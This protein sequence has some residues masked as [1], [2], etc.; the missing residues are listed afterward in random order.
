MKRYFRITLTLFIFSW[1][2]ALTFL[3]L[4]IIMG[5]TAYSEIFSLIYPLQYVGLIIAAFLSEGSNVRA[6]K[7][8]N[9][10]CVLTGMFLGLT[11]G[12][13]VF[14]I[15]IA[16][17]DKFIMFMNM[18]AEIYK[19]FTI[20]A[21]GQLFFTFVNGL[22]T[23]KLY[24]ENKDK[25]ANTLSIVY[26][27]INMASVLISALCTKDQWL[28]LS[29]NLTALFVY[30]FFVFIFNLKKFKFNF[31]F[32]SNLKYSSN[33]I[34]DAVLMLVI[35]L[36]GYSVVFSFGAEY[37]ITINLVNMITDPIWDGFE[38]VGKIAKIEL[39]Q[40]TYNY[41]KA[42]AGSS[43]ITAMYYVVALTLFFSLANVFGATISI[44]LIYIAFQL[45]DLTLDLFRIN[46]RAFL[47]LEYSPLIVG[48]RKSVV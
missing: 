22:V 5:N 8:K 26:I 43:A 3:L 13:I 17:V 29:I 7:E 42:I 46:N 21:I 24:F 47:Q 11:I 34:I 40:G 19:T 33:T 9:S 1:L 44:G 28:I 36:F 41:K 32:V 25:I 20:M 45:T 27:L 18:D 6:N 35:Y 23:E 48:D 31:S 37:I 30:C 4:G 12:I 15:I 10:D 14:G 38:A 2:N 16:F 39:S